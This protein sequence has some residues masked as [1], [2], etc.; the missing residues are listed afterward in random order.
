[1]KMPR[2]GEPKLL[3]GRSSPCGAARGKR[4]DSITSGS[5]KRPEGRGALAHGRANVLSLSRARPPRAGSA[6]RS[7]AQNEARKR[8]ASERPRVG[9]CEE[10]RGAPAGEEL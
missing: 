1:M 10:L 3:A 9:C 8:R 6:T 4:D 7:V 2:G 5:C